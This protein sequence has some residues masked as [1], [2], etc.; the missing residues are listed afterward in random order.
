MQLSDLLLVHENL[1]LDLFG[2][3]DNLHGLL[4]QRSFGQGITEG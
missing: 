3:F 2:L 1:S 4:L